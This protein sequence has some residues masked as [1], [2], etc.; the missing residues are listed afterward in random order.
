MASVCPQRILR[1]AISLLSLIPS[2][3]EEQEER[4]TNNVEELEE[5][6]RRLDKLNLTKV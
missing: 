4:I 2:L 3:E 5:L 6:I 1:E